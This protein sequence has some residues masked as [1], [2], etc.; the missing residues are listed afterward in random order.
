MKNLKYFIFTVAILISSSSFAQ[1]VNR[2]ILAVIDGNEIKEIYENMIAKRVEM[3]LNHLGF[4]VDYVDI[5]KRLPS[6]E[7]MQKYVGIVSWFTD[8][9]LSN[10]PNYAKWLTRQLNNGKKVMI[11]DQFGFDYNEN[12]I[13]TKKSIWDNFFK[14]F[15]VKYEP[16]GA[17]TS[18]I[19]IDVEY[20][21]PDITE[22][23]RKLGKDLNSFSNLQTTDKLAKVYLKLKRKDTGT[24][25]DAVFKSSVG[26]YILS[27]YAV[28]YN[29]INYQTRWLINPFKYF[30]AV[31]DADFPKPDVTT[32]NG[33][34]M[35]YSHIDG[36]GVRSMSLIDKKKNCGQVMYD[37]VLNKYNL[38]VSASFVVGDILTTVSKRERDSIVGIMKRTFE[39]PNIQPAS[40]GWAHPFIWEKKDRLIGI[41]VPG[42]TY[43]PEFEI[44]KS[45]EYLNKNIVPKG[46]KVDMFFWTGDC[47]PDYEALKYVNDHNIMNVNGG[48]TRFDNEYPSYTYVAPLFRHVNGL[49]QN[50]AIN[51]NENVYTNMWSGPY[52]GYKYIIETF[53]NTGSPIRLRAIDVYYHIYN[54]EREPS[55]NA[56]IKAYDWALT[57]EMNPAFLSE[58]LHVLKGFL[59]TKF[60]KISKTAWAVSDNGDLRTIRFDNYTGN[61]DLEKSKGVIGFN[62]LQ[63]VTYVHLDNGTISEIHLTPNYPK[64]PFLIK[65]NGKIENWTK[66]EEG[67]SFKIRNMDSLSFQIGGLSKEKKYKVKIGEQI[68]ETTTDP[69]G[70]LT[71][72]QESLGNKFIW[73]DVAIF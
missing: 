61:I 2:N 12:M 1:A 43:S 21:D 49:L 34:R 22:F 47:L 5:S 6:D 63:G 45:I 36:D 14:A 19:L 15:K 67:L 33:T 37:R 59:S 30:A 50:Y 71:F 46:K 32:L 23:E 7:E 55:L 52:W 73:R 16:R 17:T 28:Y 53:K 11:I 66:G 68:S 44:G 40:H 64:T 41:K 4:T 26:G 42:Y 29:S 48:D 57:Q 18:S 58:Y 13:P 62:S 38:P 3:P 65:A 20:K 39:L 27:S 8:N 56:I 24:V 70:T 31:F 54:A 60:S 72:R 51:S 25:C 35:F 69:N 9:V 10:A